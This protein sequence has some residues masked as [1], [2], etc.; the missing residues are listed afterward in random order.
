MNKKITPRDFRDAFVA[1]MSSERDGFATAIGF[2]TK[3]YNY[4]M[5]TT[6]YPKIARRLG[7]KCLE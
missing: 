5:R 7:L 4:Y 6:I 1:V 3:S 2:E